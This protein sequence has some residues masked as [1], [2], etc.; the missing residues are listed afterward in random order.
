MDHFFGYQFWQY[1]HFVLLLSSLNCWQKLFEIGKFILAYN[2]KHWAFWHQVEFIGKLHTNFILLG[3]VDVCFL[4]NHVFANFLLSLFYLSSSLLKMRNKFSH[5]EYHFDR[6][7]FAIQ[8]LFGKEE[9]SI[10]Y[11]VF[12]MGIGLGALTIPGITGQLAS[13]D[14]SLTPLPFQGLFPPNYFLC[15]AKGLFLSFNF[16]LN[17]IKKS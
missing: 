9:L 15:T 5:D 13:N 11:G 16:D 2:M 10:V 3:H 7:L 17:L 12:H 4:S 6:W 1:G 14:Y 8:D